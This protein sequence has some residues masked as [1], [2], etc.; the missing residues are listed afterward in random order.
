MSGVW[1]SMRRFEKRDD[2]SNELKSQAARTE[3][4]DGIS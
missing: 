2:R 3:A 1:L 4:D